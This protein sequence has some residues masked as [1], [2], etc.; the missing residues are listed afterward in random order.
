M[1]KSNQ[2]RLPPS[3]HTFNHFDL[4]GP[5]FILFKYMWNSKRD[6]FKFSGGFQAK[7]NP[8]HFKITQITQIGWSHVMICDWLFATDWN[9]DKRYESLLRLRSEPANVI[10]CIKKL[11]TIVKSGRSLV[12]LSLHRFLMNIIINTGYLC[13]FE[14]HH[15]HCDGTNPS[16]NSSNESGRLRSVPHSRTTRKLLFISARSDTG[17]C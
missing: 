17:C 1:H 14:G 16:N 4:S 6:A 7:P 8:F 3:F 5:G 10:C 11:S 13:C 15:H 9:S 2:Y 12:L